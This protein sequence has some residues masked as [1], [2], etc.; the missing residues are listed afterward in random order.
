MGRGR[1]WYDAAPSNI[2]VPA[3]SEP[4]AGET[5]AFAQ[6]APERNGLFSTD[7]SMLPH[8]ARSAAAPEDMQTPP[9]ISPP[10]D[11]RPL[12]V[13]PDDQALEEPNKQNL[14]AE[15]AHEVRGVQPR[16]HDETKPSFGED[17][18]LI[19][20]EAVTIDKVDRLLIQKKNR[21]SNLQAG[22]SFAGRVAWVGSGVTDLEVGASVLGL[23]E[24]GRKV[25]LIIRHSKLVSV[26]VLI[27][28]SEPDSLVRI[29]D[30]SL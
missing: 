13:Q 4:E 12:A 26:H 24:P 10:L 28:S 20:L 9:V 6:S 11:M 30:T 19:A 22:R 25:R 3:R 23:T 2:N 27:Y 15:P 1:D 18:V 17:D 14:A 21:L 5:A 16:F 29:Q 8:P 7:T